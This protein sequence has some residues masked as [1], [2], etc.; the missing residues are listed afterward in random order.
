M[1]WIFTRKVMSLS[2][3]IAVRHINVCDRNQHHSSSFDRRSRFSTQRQQ[4]NCSRLSSNICMHVRIAAID[5]TRPCLCYFYLHF[6]NNKTIW[7]LLQAF[8][9]ESLF[10]SKASE[11]IIASR[12][13]EKA[14]VTWFHI[15]LLF[16]TRATLKSCWHLMETWNRIW[17]H[18]VAEEVV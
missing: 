15:S 2:L 5:Y 6:H 18:P 13:G 12:R 16:F 1:T 11:G 8:V 3:T 4:T 9:S 17:S 10:P 7:I 14:R